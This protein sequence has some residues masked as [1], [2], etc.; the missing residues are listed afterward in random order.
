MRC[1]N[2]GVENEDDAEY[3]RYCSCGLNESSS[4]DS[5]RDKMQ[6]QFKKMYYIYFTAITFLIVPFFIPIIYNYF[7]HTPL[8]PIV[9]VLN[10]I[11]LITGSLFTIYFYILFYKKKDELRGQ[12]PYYSQI[13]NI[14]ILL[15]LLMITI[16]VNYVTGY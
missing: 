2:C 13:T 12:E 4:S 5:T 3:C 9:V 16:L 15:F 10:L 14:A 1:K 8:N 11:L 6:N 7:F